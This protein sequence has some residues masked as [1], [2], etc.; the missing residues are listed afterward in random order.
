MQAFNDTNCIIRHNYIR[1]YNGRKFSIWV[2]NTVG[3]GETA[4]YEQFL[5]FAQC[6]RER[7]P[8]FDMQEEVKKKKKTL[9]SFLNETFCSGI[10]C[11]LTD[12][13]KRNFFGQCRSRSDCTRRTV[14][15]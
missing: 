7:P 3:N 8:P 2:E 1:T 9:D 11:F 5:L 14:Y 15:L 12:D 10:N 13:Y 6:F 4:R